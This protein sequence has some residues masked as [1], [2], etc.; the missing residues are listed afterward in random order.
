MKS[1]ARRRGRRGRYRLLAALAAAPLAQAARAAN[2]TY[3]GPGGAW[4]DPLGWSL[5]RPPAAGDTVLVQGTLGA[6]SILTLDTSATG[7]LS[8]LTIDALTASSI[9]LSQPDFN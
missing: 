6:S 3:L 5:A 1:P 2:D 7:A 9:T 8:S 4:S